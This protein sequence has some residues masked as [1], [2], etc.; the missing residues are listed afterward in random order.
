MR[1][2]ELVLKQKRIFEKEKE[3]QFKAIRIKAINDEI[4]LLEESGRE[5]D[6]LRIQQLKAQREGLED[7][8]DVV[9]ENSEFLSNF[10]E[11][12]GEELDKSFEK[13]LQAIDKQ[14]NKTSSN[15]DR[16]R[17][18]AI[19]GQL[20][21]GESLA[22]EQKQEIELERERERT[23]KRQERTKAL[24]AVLS[25]FNAN[26]GDLPKTIADITVFKSRSRR[27]DSV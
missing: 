20:E 8:G 23:L 3:A 10:L 1:L 14:L 7:L 6:E 18:K 24:F 25:S 2:K 9:K 4:K 17:D 22:F 12:V 11:V 27:L 15:I 16:L 19:E 13:R 26:D 5:K 21:S